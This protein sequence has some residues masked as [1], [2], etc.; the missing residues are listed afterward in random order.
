MAQAIPFSQAQ[1]FAA[2]YWYERLQ[3]TFGPTT[4]PTG[5]TPVA[6]ANKINRQQTPQ[7]LAKID[8]V[9]A[10]QNAN[11]LLDYQFDSRRIQAQA[12]QGYTDAMPSGVRVVNIL[13]LPAKDRLALSVVNN[14]GAPV[15]SYQLNYQVTMK[16]LTVADKLLYGITQ[17]TQ[18]EQEA[19]ADRSIDV[20]GLF[21]KGLVPI[22]ESAQ[23]ERTYRNRVVF[24]TER[25]LHVQ[26]TTSD[27]AFLTIRASEGGPDTFLV[28]RSIAI[29]GAANVVISVDRDDDINYMGVNGAAFVDGDDRPWDVFVPALNFLTFHIQ[30]TA[31]VA[32][33]PIRIGIWHV[34][35][36]NLLRVRF[37]LVARG[38]VPDHTYLRAIAGVA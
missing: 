34:K 1:A 8:K 6:V 13:E 5:I 20:Q 15:P 14:T 12:D 22:P 35:F 36:S 30:A 38:E 31:P 3:Y 4:V 37:G 16:R 32:N 28:L 18:E 10:T 33:V 17:F 23:I 7:W 21:E 11:V 27:T 2:K 19:L 29:E 26:A 25:T 9:A 24:A